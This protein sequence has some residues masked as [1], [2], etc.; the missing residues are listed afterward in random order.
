M[1]NR[2]VSPVVALAALAGLSTSA[3]LL[4]VP[5]NDSR[6]TAVLVTLGTSQTGTTVTGTNAGD[7]AGA[8][9]NS[10]TS[11]DVWYRFNCLA[12]TGVSVSTCGGAGWDTVLQAFNV[13]AGDTLGASLI[14]NDDDCGTQSS[15]GFAA[16]AGN[17]YWIRVAGYSGATGTFTVTF[18]ATIP[19][20]PTPVSH[21]L[22]AAPAGLPALPSAPARTTGPDVTIGNL[23]DTAYYGGGFPWMA[24]SATAGP[25]AVPYYGYA[26]GTDSWNIGDI[27]VEWQTSNQLHPVIGQ[28]MYR[29]KGG[30]FEQIGFSWL[31]HGFASTNS[32]G[33]PDIGACDSP[34][35]GGAQLG[36][37]C[38]DLYGS[39]LNGSHSYL[40]PRF[41]VNATTGVYTYPWSGLVGTIDNTDVVSRRIAVAYDDIS[42]DSNAGAYYFIDCNYTTQDDAQ[43]GNS[44]NN[45][46]A[47]LLKADTLFN[48]AV[49][50]LTNTYRRTTALELWAQT[51]TSVA[52]SPVDMVESTMSVTDKWNHWTAATPD[53][54]VKPAA[55]WVTSTRNQNTRYLVA[56][57]A[58]N[59]G[60]GT[61][62]YEYAVMNLN[63]K[64]A[65]GSFG[66]RLPA[67]AALTNIDFHAPKYHSGERVLNNPWLNN[68]GAAGKMQWTV[69]PATRTA[70]VPGM[71]AAVNF[72]PNALGYGTLYNYRFRSTAAPSLG[73]A[74]LGLYRVP[75]ATG[76]QGTS[77]AVTGV[78]VPTVCTA[79]MGSQGGL[80]GPDALL[81]NNDFIVFIDAFFNGDMLMADIGKQGGLA[82]P[83]N[84]LD[85][86]DFIVFIDAFFNGCGV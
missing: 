2:R 62:D 61:Y 66:V 71:A 18:T 56:S 57:K 26:V 43:W 81:D 35:N 19:P 83:D 51:D 4:A 25:S 36:V 38:S 15:I 29:W 7:T 10:G 9:G 31:K 40:G 49:S 3:T 86:N 79:D 12:D 63:S 22:Q 32:G 80:A 47:R 73:T 42:G 76:Y 6:A 33:F 65:G 28:Q 30:R 34:P 11:P 46:S 21:A 68:G 54:T 59:N 82:G 37:N 52:L 39:S 70:T 64:R 1:M 84:A 14:C 77:L 69:N 16:T 27:P 74:R 23:S 50:T 24:D 58:I 72:E 44:R 45:Y 48:G 13:G 8:C 85:N 53:A 78:K 17:S 5:P 60:T 20:P 55:Q 67:A 41:D 75:N